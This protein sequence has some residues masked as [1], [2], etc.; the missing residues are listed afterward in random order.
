MEAS[1]SKRARLSVANKI[2]G[3]WRY[4]SVAVWLIF[5]ASL[6]TWWIIFSYRQIGRLAAIESSGE[7]VRHQTM[8][9]YEGATLLLCLLAGGVALLYLTV[10]AS[11]KNR[12]IAEFFAAFTHELKT[13]LAS[14]RLQAELLSERL[15]KSENKHI[16]ER[17]LADTRR[18]NL[19][20][21]NSL[22]LAHLEGRKDFIEKINLR[23]LLTELALDWPELG[24]NFDGTGDIKADRRLLAVILSNIARNAVVHGAAKNLNLAIEAQSS[25]PSQLKLII[26]DDGSGFEGDPAVLGRDLSRHYNGSGSGVG[27]FLCRRLAQQMAGKLEVRSGRPHFCVELTLPAA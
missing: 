13:P 11:R 23:E 16:A 17:L 3:T 1:E 14:L 20:L 4:L 6:A 12:Q 24:L 5:T 22:L 19:Q 21:E 15:V 25:R 7:L 26:S 8:L 2:R 9:L 27:L 18:L 10:S